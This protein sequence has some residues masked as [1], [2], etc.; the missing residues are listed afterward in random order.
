MGLTSFAYLN[1]R[2]ILGG[3]AE[4][5]RGE[6]MLLPRSRDAGAGCCSRC[7]AGVIMGVGEVCG[8][9]GGV[10][11]E[12]WTCS[13]SVVLERLRTPSRA[14]DGGD[15]GALLPHAI[16]E[17]CRSP[18]AHVGTINTSKTGAEF[19]LISRADLSLALRIPGNLLLDSCLANQLQLRRCGSLRHIANPTP[20]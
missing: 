15:R 9:H 1:I 18:G 7:V 13:S 4:G 11:G 10:S 17:H 5:S 16:A 14:C 3:I 19:Q 8:L 20:T 2:R 12:A 6:I